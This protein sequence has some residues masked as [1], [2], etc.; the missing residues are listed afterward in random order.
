[1][2]LYLLIPLSVLLVFI[3][4]VIFWWSLRSG[5]FD[6]MEGPAY[7]MLMDDRDSPRRAASKSNPEKEDIEAPSEKAEIAA[8]D[9]PEAKR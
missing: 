6:D 4:G 1:M 8:E 7:K 9:D 5:Q 2:G 3:I